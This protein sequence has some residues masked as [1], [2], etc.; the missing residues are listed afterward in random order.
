MAQDENVSVVSWPYEPASLE[1]RFDPN[2][3][4]PVTIRFAD[5]AAQVIVAT[6]P[7]MPLDVNMNMNVVAKEAIPVCIKLCEPICARSDY[8]IGLNIFDNPFASITVRGITQIAACGEEPPTKERICAN[9]DQL[10]PGTTF[11]QPF[12]VQNLTFTPLGP[13]LRA[14]SFGEPAGRIKLGF[15]RAGVRVDFPQPV[16]NVSLLINNYAAPDLQVTAYSGAN[17]VSQFTVSISNTVRQVPVGANGITGITVV[18]G[19][20]EAG[21]VEI[22]YYAA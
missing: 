11:N 17:I 22:C 1:H 2:N 16:E 7:K 8:T 20:N 9:F 4:V 5:S 6:D 15:P 12:T 14:V 21:L 18:G 13:E 10:Q 19:D 3:P